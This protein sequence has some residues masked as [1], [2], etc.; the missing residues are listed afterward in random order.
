MGKVR[1]S[2]ALPINGERITV[3]RVPHLRCRRCGE[4][5]L[6]PAEAVAFDRQALEIYRRKYGLLSEQ[7]IREIRE[8]FGLTQ[9]AL[10]RLLRLGANTVSRWESGR[11]VQSASLDVM[12]RML[13]DVRGTLAFLRRHVA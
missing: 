13:R 1:R 11:N 6:S 12:L 2:L 8:R 9:A 7:E 10:S 4:T 5:L 3:P